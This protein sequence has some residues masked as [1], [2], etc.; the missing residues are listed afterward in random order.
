MSS[1]RF[2]RCGVVPA[3][4]HTR[5]DIR[6]LLLIAWIPVIALSGA[7]SKEQSTQ[8]TE[9]PVVYCSV[10]EEFARTVF[11]EFERQ[12]GIKPEVLFDTEAG[13]TTG[14]VR[15]IEA[16]RDRPR[17]DV[18][19]SSEVFNTIT[20]T[21]QGL[22]ESYR[23]K[24]ADDIEAQ[25][26]CPRDFWTGFAA[27]GR[28]VAFNTEKLSR[29]QAPKRWIDLADAKWAGK[30]VMANPQFGT[31]RGHVAA[32]FALWGE[33]KAVG[34][35]E[36]LAKNKVRIADGNAAAVRMVGRGEAE[37]CMTD[38]DDVWVAQKQGLPVDLV[39]PSMVDGKGT[40]WIPNTVAI[41]KGCRHP[42]SARK[43]VD[44]LASAELERMMAKTESRNVPVRS[45]LVK[46][47][48][49]TPPDAVQV[50]YSAVAHAMPDAIRR[51][52]EILLR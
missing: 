30:L 9:A 1:E 22:L 24:T 2:T 4:T 41:L 37:L 16:E 18:F 44:F 50:T 15:K 20:L 23:P 19:W 11:A 8:Q 31:T 45:A 40:L 28:V 27:R 14:L 39:Y 46:E 42:E 33:D 35:L 49:M 52:R 6:T 32:M 34:F 12:T 5:F 43:L 25:F 13:K 21:M 48:G 51:A 7:C 36:A 38:T 29:D 17:A 47:L 3:S 26:R 10:D